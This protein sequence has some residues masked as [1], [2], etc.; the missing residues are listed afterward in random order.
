MHC[1]GAH[2][3]HLGSLFHTLSASPTNIVQTYL[4]ESDN[5]KV[6]M[7][8]TEEITACTALGKR[9]IIHSKLV[10]N[11]AIH[12][13]KTQHIV[14]KELTV[15]NSLPLS[16]VVMHI[17]NLKQEGSCGVLGERIN[18]MRNLLPYHERKLMLEISA[19]KGND[20]GWNQEHLR[21]IWETLD[22]N[23]V[24]LCFDTQHGFAS[25]MTLLQT[26]ED[27][28]N[29]MSLFYDIT[30]RY[31]DVIHLNDSKVPFASRIDRHSSIGAGYIW[32]RY[33]SESYFG[34]TNLGLVRLKQ[35][36]ESY[37]IPAVSESPHPLQDV[38]LW[39]SIVYL[40]K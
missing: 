37:N 13:C 14:E 17:G 3:S 2:H 33:S 26:T 18:S 31:P 10:T 39:D 23:T 12:N 20:I 5:Y 38:A 19:G 15:A 28:D 9:C 11:L 21:K 32:P 22:R 1:C 29:S 30:G 35:Y 36:C 40:T 7:P 25:G 6:V 27:V 4:G 34:R 24:G 16:C 8:S